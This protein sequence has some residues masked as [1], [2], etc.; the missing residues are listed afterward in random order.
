[1]VTSDDSDSEAAGALRRPAKAARP[2]KRAAPAKRKPVAS[3]S[4]K[5]AKRFRGGRAGPVVLKLDAGEQQMVDDERPAVR[6]SK[7]CGRTPLRA[8]K[9]EKQWNGNA[10][11]GVI[12]KTTVYGKW[13]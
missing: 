1:M 11:A 2:K 13:V 10:V 12:N 8:D 5:P 7:P 9:T 3:E 6:R 4:A